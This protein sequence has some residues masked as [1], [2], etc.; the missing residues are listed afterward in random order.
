M[1]PQPPDPWELGW[2]ALA[3]LGTAAA[4][5]LSVVAIIVAA[6]AAKAS[7]RVA[8]TAE[9]QLAAQTM[10]IVVEVP[11]G[12]QLPEHEIATFIGG[13]EIAVSR[14]G[15]V[16]L[17]AP[18][19][20][21]PAVVS[22]PIQNVGTGLAEVREAG[23]VFGPRMLRLRGPGFSL[24][25]SPL[26]LLPQSRDR[27][28]LVVGRGGPGSAEIAATARESRDIEARIEYVDI[29][30]ERRYVTRL[31]LYRPKPGGAWR[32]LRQETA[33]QHG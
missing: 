20:G 19:E 31:L 6:R 2:D 32:I 4:T 24:A 3:S 18:E 22:I 12:N 11:L 23:L 10:P 14:E 15:E 30:G 16:I 26:Y 27:L 29:S 13:H 17:S 21:R 8:E 28:G 25:E 9:A 33:Q 7:A 1:A 5:V